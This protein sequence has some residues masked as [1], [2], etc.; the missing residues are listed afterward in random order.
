MQNRCCVNGS[1][2]H[3][4]SNAH[5]LKLLTKMILRNFISLQVFIYY[6]HEKLTAV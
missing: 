4:S 1:F 5:A 2:F 6:L 3:N